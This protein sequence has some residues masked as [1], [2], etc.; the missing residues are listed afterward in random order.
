MILNDIMLP[1]IIFFFLFRKVLERMVRGGGVRGGGR[2]NGRRSARATDDA[3]EAMDDV[4]AEVEGVS[5]ALETG[6]S[7]AAAEG[8]PGAPAEVLR[9]RLD[10]ARAE[11]EQAKSDADKAIKEKEAMQKQ[12]DEM[13]AALELAKSNVGDV[14]PV[15]ENLVETPA[16]KVKF[17]FTFKFRILDVCVI[18]LIRIFRRGRGR[19]RWQLPQFAVYPFLR[20]AAS[21]LSSQ[22]MARPTFVIFKKSWFPESSLTQDSDFTIPFVVLKCC[23]Y[24]DT[25][26][27]AKEVY[28][29]TGTL[30]PPGLR[31]GKT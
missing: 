29:C 9:R 22:I 17:R 2:G 13:R 26:Q 19:K 28:T 25:L 6:E 12:M 4:R 7:S 30:L 24:F 23:R 10:K 5:A 3:A 21:F 16:R 1:F 18:Y 8:A 11:A 14:V 31:K 27:S 15:A 20:K